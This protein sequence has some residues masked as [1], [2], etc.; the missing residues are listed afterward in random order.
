MDHNTLVLFGATGDLTQRKLLPAI[1]S[2]YM[3]GRFVNTDII[4]IGRKN[5][6]TEGFRSHARD[7]CRPSNDAR[8]S[9]FEQ[10][11]EF[12]QTDVEDK[13]SFDALCHH[14]ETRQN[15]LFMLATLPE[16]FPK[17][18]ERIAKIK[19]AGFKRVMIEKPFGH[20]VKSAKSLHRLLSKHFGDQVYPIDHYLGKS[21]VRNI[22]VLRFSN[23][24]F[25][26]V[27]NHKYIDNVQII[28]SEDQGTSRRIE[29]YDKTG[30]LQDMVQSHLLQMLARVAMEPPKTWAPLSVSAAKANVLKKARPSEQVVFGQYAGYESEVG[31]PTDTE[32]FVALKAFVDTPRWK[33]VPFYL[34]SG[35]KLEKRFAE[36][37]ITF[38]PAHYMD[39]QTLKDTLTITL[40]PDEKFALSVNLKEI[41]QTELKSFKMEYCQSCD[42]RP[43]APQNY[44]IL[45]QE[46]LLGKKTFFA[47]WKEIEACWKFVDA[48]QNKVR[49]QKPL[50]YAEGSKGPQT[51]AS[52]TEWKDYVG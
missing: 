51:A 41:G 26:P 37:I 6:G 25:E 32:T 16:L 4:G 43:N 1:W 38:K 23:P 49:G 15:L 13:K 7:A 2:G 35:K 8:W 28:Q 33:G 9:A 17:I 39:Q 44:E 19:N 48:V 12:F 31:H 14:L 11:L 45:F 52:I 10:K 50:K 18:T 3:N 47:S 30:A 46:A 5:W 21:T 42:V 34:L 40:Q 24:L 27:W 20:D 36:V 29:F 22:M